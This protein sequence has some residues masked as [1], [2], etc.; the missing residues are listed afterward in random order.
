MVVP[1]SRLKFG[2]RAFSI[3]APTA[4]NSIPAD[5][6]ATLNTAMFK[7]NLKTF[8]FRE[9]YSTFWLNSFVTFALL[10]CPFLFLVYCIFLRSGWSAF[11][12]S[13]SRF[14][15][16]LSLNIYLRN[17]CIFSCFFF[18]FVCCYFLPWLM[19]KEVCI[20]PK[21]YFNFKLWA[22]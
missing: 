15:L 4:W 1:R 9:S 17:L 18:F 2:E 12:V 10:H 20:I 7:K 22:F 21:F 3:A 14:S 13:H 19:D 6:R 8:L 5:L 11:A 16:S